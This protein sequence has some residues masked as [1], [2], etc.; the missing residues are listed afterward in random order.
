MNWSLNARRIAFGGV[1]RL[2][3]VDAAADQPGAVFVQRQLDQF[4]ERAFVRGPGALRQPAPRAM[5]TMS[6]P[7]SVKVC[8][9]PVI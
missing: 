9:P 8:C 2:L 3:A 7:C 5:A 1:F 6:A 4:L